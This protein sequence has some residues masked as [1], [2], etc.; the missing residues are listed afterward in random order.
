MINIPVIFSIL[1]LIASGVVLRRSLRS[2]ASEKVLGRLSSGFISTDKV[3]YGAVQ[4][5]LLRTGIQLD[6]GRVMLLV[7]V[8]LVLLV[9]EIGRASC[10]ERV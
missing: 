8:W 6:F 10:R 5:E 7:A 2:A 3:N 1:L 4:R 9:I